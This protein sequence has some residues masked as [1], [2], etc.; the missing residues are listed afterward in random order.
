MAKKNNSNKIAEE[1]QQ[2]RRH[3]CFSKRR[4]G[5]FHK[6]SELCNKC[7][8]KMAIVMVSEAG[9]PYA[10]GHP[11]TDEVLDRYLTTTQAINPPATSKNHQ[12][13]TNCEEE[14]K[15]TEMDIKEWIDKEFEACQTVQELKALK[16]KYTALLENINKKIQDSSSS[17]SSSRGKEKEKDHNL[18]GS[19]C[20]GQFNICMDGDNTAKKSNFDNVG[21]NSGDDDSVLD[22]LNA[23]PLAIYNPF[24]DTA[25]SLDKVY[26]GGFDD[27]G[28]EHAPANQDLND[29]VWYASWSED[30]PVSSS[31]VEPTANSGGGHDESASRVNF[32]RRLP[33]PNK[34]VFVYNQVGSESVHNEVFPTPTSST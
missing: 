34:K 12:K 5:L 27:V 23:V 13:Q 15:R 19:S 21:K 10:F 30:H 17:P 9:K 2:Q 28:V 3:V 11:S 16:I 4:K 8:S 26:G 6:A 24:N 29:V 1:E 20:V 33:L 31:F 14:G 32:Q 25:Y 18:F 7:G 22:V